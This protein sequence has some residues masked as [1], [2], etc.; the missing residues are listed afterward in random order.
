[1]STPESTHAAVAIEIAGLT[2]RYPGAESDALADVDRE[3]LRSAGGLLDDFDGFAQADGVGYVE[4][5]HGYGGVAAVDEDLNGCL[6][7]E[8]D[9]VGVIRWDFDAD[10]GASAYDGAC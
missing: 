4:G 6:A 1:M 9:V 7:S 8:E 2:Y 3:F 5:L 10:F